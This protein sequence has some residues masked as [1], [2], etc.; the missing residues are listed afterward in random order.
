MASGVVSI[1]RLKDIKLTVEPKMKEQ[2]ETQAEQ[3]KRMTVQCRRGSGGFLY[4]R[5]EVAVMQDER[6]LRC[7]EEH[8]TFS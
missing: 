7:R 6:V 4:N 2:Y 8:G 5:H 3:R 1:G